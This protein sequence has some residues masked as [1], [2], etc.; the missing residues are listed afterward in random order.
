MEKEFYIQ[1][2]PLEKEGYCAPGAV[3]S[4]LLS[5]DINDYRQAD[6]YKHISKPEW[7]TQPREIV[8]MFA[9]AISKEHIFAKKN[10]KFKELEEIFS[11]PE[12]V[13][14]VVVDIQ[15]DLNRIDITTG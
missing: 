12:R 3:E 5:F 2:R 14:V 1:R 4:L 13:G 9:E 11:R 6:M 8:A 10:W 15:D 7:G